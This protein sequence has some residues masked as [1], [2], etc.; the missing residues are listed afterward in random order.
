MS[1]TEQREALARRMRRVHRALPDV[2]RG[3]PV[4][5]RGPTPL[6]VLAAETAGAEGLGEFAAL[7][8]NAAALL[9][10]APTR[11]TD[12]LGRPVAEAETPVALRLH[13]SLFDP[14]ALRTLADPTED[15]LLV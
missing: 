1:G 11:A 4:V 7:R 14:R 12:I 9:L 5:L 3:T 8:G 10:L 13:E 6:V 2:R 15:V